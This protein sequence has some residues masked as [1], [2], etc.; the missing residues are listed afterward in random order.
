M[1]RSVRSIAR[2]VHASPE[3]EEAFRESRHSSR[4]RGST[5]TREAGTS[6]GT[7]ARELMVLRKVPYMPANFS[8][9]IIRKRLEDSGR[10]AAVRLEAALVP[11]EIVYRWREPPTNVTENWLGRLRRFRTTVVPWMASSASLEG[12]RILEV[13]AGKGSSSSTLWSLGSW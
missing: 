2:G 4:F 1:P 8:P 7:L 3:R 6:E 10:R 9:A 11:R 12:S 13:G 5:H